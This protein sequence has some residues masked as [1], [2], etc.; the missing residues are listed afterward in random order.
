MVK[1]SE[2][3][4]IHSGVPQGVVD[5]FVRRLPKQVQHAVML[6]YADD[7]TLMK[8]VPGAC[9]IHSGKVEKYTP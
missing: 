3:C 7:T 6:C 1:R 8:R 4:Q 5:L 9:C 2:R